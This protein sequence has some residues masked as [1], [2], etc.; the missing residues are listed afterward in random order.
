[1]ALSHCH[2]AEKHTSHRWEDER[3]SG[4]FN[5]WCPGK[6]LS[7]DG[8]WFASGIP[9]RGQPKRPHFYLTD[10]R[11]SICGHGGRGTQRMHY[12]L[13]TQRTVEVDK[14][15]GQQITLRP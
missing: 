11:Q 13:A 12:D 4:T 8:Q 2:D 15:A 7:A 10:E 9:R 6:Y 5:N 3:P 14:R 1:M